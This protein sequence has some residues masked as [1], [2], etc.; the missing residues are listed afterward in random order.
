MQIMKASEALKLFWISQCGQEWG[1]NTGYSKSFAV[2]IA[3]VQVLHMSAL[4]TTQR[5]S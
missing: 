5:S 2:Q 1:F 3:Q 4:A